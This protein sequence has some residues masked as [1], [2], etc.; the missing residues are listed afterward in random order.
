MKA[1]LGVATR[2]IA[3]VGLLLAP[4][5]RAVD[6]DSTIHLS[7]TNG[8]QTLDLPLV[9]GV[10]EFKILGTTNLTAPFSVVGGGNLSGYTWLQPSVGGL[11]FYRV[12]MMPKDSN[13]VVCAR[14]ARAT[15]SHEYGPPGAG[16]WG[17]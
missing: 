13:S 5:S 6:D 3:S 12:E 11:Q 4:L 10:D 9:S 7:I 1:G 17:W 8:I 14:N 15:E 16:P 2:L